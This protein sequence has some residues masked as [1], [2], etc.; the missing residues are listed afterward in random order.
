MEVTL[1]SLLFII[2]FLRLPGTV[3][4]STVHRSGRQ[5]DKLRLSRVSVIPRAG[6][7]AWPV[8][9]IWIRRSIIMRHATCSRFLIDDHYHAAWLFY[10]I[11]ML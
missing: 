10:A 6:R 9:G 3:E 2:A 4:Y 5:T 7:A 8:V 1:E 11:Y